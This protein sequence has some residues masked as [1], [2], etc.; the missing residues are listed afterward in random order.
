MAQGQGK[1]RAGILEYVGSR[2]PGWSSNLGL[3]A[4]TATTITIRGSNGSALTPEN[5]GWITTPSATA[6]QLT[7][8]PVTANVDILLT[9]AHWG[10]G[11]LGDL[12]DQP[13]SVL[14]LNN[15]GSLV[16]GV[17][18]HGGRSLVLDSEDSATATDINL[19]NEVLV[20]SALSADAQAVHF[21][22]FKA[23]FDDTGGASEDL[24][25]IQTGD[26]DMV[27]GGN[28][29]ILQQTKFLAADQTT[30]GAM[31]G[32]TFSN[33]RAGDIAEWSG[34]MMWDAD[35]SGGGN[36]EAS[37]DFDD[38]TTNILTLDQEITLSGATFTS[39]VGAKSFHI[40]RIVT[41]DNLNIAAFLTNTDARG[42]GTAAETFASLIIKGETGNVLKPAVFS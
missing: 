16:W 33:L 26:G 20:S 15:N 23:N 2:T 21:G 35:A 37:Y 40:N 8:F 41:G 34:V 30:T 12:T 27:V 24:W 36:H 6:G 9:G 17:A 11:T 7:L 32:L 25:A 5:P 29:H 42:D 28:I 4:P 39:R 38:N 1:L 22:Y 19:W 3:G 31:T 13:L 10:F 18:Q 14:A